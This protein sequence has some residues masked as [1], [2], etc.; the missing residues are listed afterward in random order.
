LLAFARPRDENVVWT[1]LERFARKNPVR[2]SILWTM[3]VLSFVCAVTPFSLIA[4]TCVAPF[5]GLAMAGPAMNFAARIKSAGL[6]ESLLQAP[7]PESTYH[8]AFEYYFRIPVLV[9]LSLSL[10]NLLVAIAVYQISRIG[11]ERW[12]FHH[13]Y[14][15]SDTNPLF[16][17]IPWGVS[18]VVGL[19]TVW[20]C[21]WAGIRYGG[22]R[23]RIG[24]LVFVLAPCISYF[25]VIGLMV[26]VVLGIIGYNQVRER[27]PDILRAQL[28]ID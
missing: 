8:E 21:Y 24:C 5:M 3:A 13:L 9:T 19:L 12:L 25:I 18:L 26:L 16:F 20:C 15:G 7:L 28:G 17:L 2:N 4:W 27:Y 6:G 1:L 23:I 10:L 14:H 11:Q 22:Q